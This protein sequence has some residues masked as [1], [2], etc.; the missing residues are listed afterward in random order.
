M[1][2]SQRLRVL[3]SSSQ[4]NGDIHLN[5]ADA[6]KSLLEV[7]REHRIPINSSCGGHGTCGTCR[8]FLETTSQPMDLPRNVQEQ[9]FWTSRGYPTTHPE[10]LSCQILIGQLPPDCWVK[11]IE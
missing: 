4:L 3:A 6:S 9:E 2:A 7:L 8:V 1:S 11:L 10:R 5:A